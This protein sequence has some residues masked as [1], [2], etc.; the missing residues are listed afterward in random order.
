MHRPAARGIHIGLCLSAQA[1]A[2]TAALQARG[3]RRQRTGRDRTSGC[4]PGAHGARRPGCRTA[5]RQRA[6]ALDAPHMEQLRTAL[7]ACAQPGQLELLERKTRG[8]KGNTCT[9]RP[10]AASHCWSRSISAKA[11]ASV[12]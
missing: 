11:H 3:H 10:A 2:A 1:P 12:T 4:D 5:D 9:A 7:G 8:R 6:R